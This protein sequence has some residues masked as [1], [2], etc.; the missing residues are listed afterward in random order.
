MPQRRI[1]AYFSYAS[2]PDTSPTSSGTSFLDL[3]YPLR[4]YIYILSGLVRFCPINLNRSE[5][6]GPKCQVRPYRNYGCFYKVRRFDG[7]YILGGDEDWLTRCSC[8][9]L[10]IS[11]LYVSRIISDEVSSI[12]Y[13]ENKFTISRSGSWGLRPL[14][15]LTRHAIH[16][17][18]SLTVILNSCSCIFAYGRTTIPVMFP[19]HPLC[20][21]HGLHDK[22]LGS[23]ARQDRVTRQEWQVILQILADNVQPRLLRLSFICDTRDLQT[24]RDIA[25]SLGCLP[26]LRD[27]SIRL[28]QNLDWSTYLLARSICLQ[29]TGKTPHSTGHPTTPHLPDEV[30]EHILSFTE[31]VAPFQLEWCPVRGLAPFDC[32]KT[33]T[34]SLEGCCCSLYYAAYATGCTCWRLPLSLFLVNKRMHRIA[35]SIFYSKNTFFIATIH[36]KCVIW[37]LE[38]SPSIPT[39]TTQF[40]NRLPSYALPHLRSI[41]VGFLDFWPQ[42]VFNHRAIADLK[43]G[44]DIMAQNLDL[45]KLTISLQ[46]DSAKNFITNKSVDEWIQACHL[47]VQPLIHTS[48]IKRLF[49]Y[50]SP[51]QAKHY[52]PVL[53]KAV[54]GDN[55]DAVQHGKYYA[56]VP[57]WYNGYSREG[58]VYQAD[59]QKVWPPDYFDDSHFVDEDDL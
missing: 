26:L 39:I 19:C 52:E 58:P 36:R 27:C 55:Y 37:S 57:L 11:L 6:D 12:L 59:G 24:A 48:R 33:C 3:P 38:K 29:L 51:R 56:K 31:L 7:R 5:L 28:G 1:D 2:I 18:R 47:I 54:L 14:R 46:I 41:T 35:T 50:I 42:S 53:E 9:P 25:E 22:P 30:L 32:C 45:S 40:L 49:V 20:R 43:K 34:D 23:V 4:R 16:S 8:P 15:R 10:P 17:L 44:L 13:S 21:S